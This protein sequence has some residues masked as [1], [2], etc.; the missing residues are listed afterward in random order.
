[1]TA[2][3]AGIYGIL[4]ADLEQADLLVR[5]EAA[6][7]GGIRILQYR[8][9]K[10]GD[11][12]ASQRA[13]ALRALTRDY[14]ATFI[15]NDSVPLAVE[16]EA[17]GVHLG[18]SDVTDLSRLRAETGHGLI[19]GVSCQGEAAFAQHA[20]AHGADYVAFGAVFPTATKREAVVIGLPRLAKAR[21]MLPERNIVAIGGISEENLG[22]V[23]RAGADAAAVISSLFEP[24][25]G[26]EA[27]AA[28]M[29]QAW[30]QAGA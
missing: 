11:K 22:R 26:I 8:D 14:G 19:V 25:A 28:R 13:K 15:V 6:L 18:R 21:Q 23:R 10:Q 17:D 12:R 5:A 2:R 3:V 29:V 24:A 4:P 27:R 7:A 9:K 16:V 1:M 30:A 20:V